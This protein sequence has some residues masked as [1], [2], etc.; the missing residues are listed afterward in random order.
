MHGHFSKM[1]FRLVRGAIFAAKA[2]G[3]IVEEVNTV[4]TT[5]A[6]RLLDIHSYYTKDEHT[7][8]RGLE[9]RP[10]TLATGQPIAAPVLALMSLVDGI[11]ET[12]AR[13][14]IEYMGNLQELVVADDEE[15]LE[16]P[17]WG[18]TTVYRL[19]KAL[20]RQF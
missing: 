3:I 15:L 12:K 8:F 14:A 1:P 20:D 11:G 13:T 10:H 7:L 17:G 9:K 4:P 2:H 6:R 18:P 19:H 5:I 16:I